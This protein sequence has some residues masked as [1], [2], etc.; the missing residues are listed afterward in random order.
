MGVVTAGVGIA[1]ATPS[2]QAARRSRARIRGIM[3]FMTLPPLMLCNLS[4][5]AFHIN[6]AEYPVSGEKV[7]YM[8]VY[9]RT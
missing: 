2:P 9:K 8:A 4:E 3:R 5:R 1:S 7:I 6:H